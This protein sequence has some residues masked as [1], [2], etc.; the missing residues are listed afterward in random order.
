LTNEKEKSARQGESLR[1]FSDFLLGLGLIT[2]FGLPI[3]AA[4]AWAGTEYQGY[5]P[6]WL[7][8]TCSVGLFFCIVSFLLRFYGW[9]L[10]NKL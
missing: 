2:A 1:G 9:W 10:R 3:L 5:C 7:M 8:V 4:T 6:G